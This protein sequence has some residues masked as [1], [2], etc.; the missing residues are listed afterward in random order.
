MWLGAKQVTGISHLCLV[1]YF[2]FYFL[3]CYADTDLAGRLVS[4]TSSFLLW[5]CPLHLQ[6]SQ[7]HH[8]ELSFHGKGTWERK[9]GERKKSHSFWMKR[10][11][12]PF[13]Q[14]SLK[15]K[16]GTE[17]QNYTWLPVLFRKHQNPIN[18]MCL[19]YSECQRNNFF[20]K[21]IYNFKRP[22]S[23]SCRGWN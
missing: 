9:G 2:Y 23:T 11:C 13:I 17:Q 16:T 19:I 3:R 14:H 6:E 18:I 10:K 21:Q 8:E 5:L 4:Q 12:L 7:S 20:L 22:G 1:F 15:V